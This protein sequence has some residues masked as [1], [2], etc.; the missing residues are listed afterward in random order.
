MKGRGVSLADVKL[1]GPLG[2]QNPWLLSVPGTE[3]ASTVDQLRSR[4]GLT[5]D[6]AEG[7]AYTSW[8]R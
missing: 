1:F 6:G 2:E 5:A 7:P 4:G 8:Q 3:F